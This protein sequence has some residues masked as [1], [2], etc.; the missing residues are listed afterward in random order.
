VA[1]TQSRETRSAAHTLGIDLHVLNASTERDFDAVFANL[2]QLGVGGLVIA[3]EPLFRGRIKQLGDLTVRH[4]VPAIFG[5][6]DF[7]AAGGLLSYAADSRE[8]YRLAGI[9]KTAKALGLTLP[10]G[11]LSIANELIE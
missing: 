11:L 4:A 5:G 3:S 6:H 7:A 1:E 8:T 9:L 2:V 10:S